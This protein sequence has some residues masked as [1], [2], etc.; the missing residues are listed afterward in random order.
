MACE[1]NKF[2][3]PAKT[4]VKMKP[5]PFHVSVLSICYDTLIVPASLTKRCSW[6]ENFNCALRDQ[7]YL[8]LEGVGVEGKLVFVP[9]YFQT[10][11]Q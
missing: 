3:L 7:S 6:A 9:N 10:P 2:E 4:S 8:K 1:K 11:T 5:K